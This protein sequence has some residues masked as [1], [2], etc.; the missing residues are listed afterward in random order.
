MPRNTRTGRGATGFD[1][2]PRWDDPDLK[3]GNGNSAAQQQRG[4][5]VRMEFNYVAPEWFIDPTYD[6]RK[7]K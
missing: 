7:K 4:A 5:H 3:C 6:L 1:R 2:R